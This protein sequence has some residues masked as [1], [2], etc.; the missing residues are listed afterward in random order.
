MRRA[1]VVVGTTALDPPRRPR[2]RF[3]G[4]TIVVPLALTGC[5]WVVASIIGSTRWTL[6]G[7]DRDQQ[8]PPARVGRVYTTRAGD[9]WRSVARRAHISRAR[10]HALNPRDSARGPIVPG[11]RLL[12]RP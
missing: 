5:V 6:T 4:W 11:E 9:S 7:S 3:S 12:L 8:R 2:R 1:E 10:L